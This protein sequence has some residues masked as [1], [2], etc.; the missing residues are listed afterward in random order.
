MEFALEVELM[1]K[2]AASRV[3]V[4]PLRGVCFEP[5]RVCIITERMSKG[6]VLNVIRSPQT[7]EDLLKEEPWKSSISLFTDDIV[8][9][10]IPFAFKLYIAAQCA[11][12]LRDLHDAG[13]V[14]RDVKAKNFLVDEKW[15]VYIADLGFGKDSTTSDDDTLTTISKVYRKFQHVAQISFLLCLWR[16]ARQPLGTYRYMAP[17]YVKDAGIKITDKLDIYSFGVMLWEIFTG[18]VPFAKFRSETALKDFLDEVMCK[19]FSLSDARAVERERLQP[20]GQSGISC[21]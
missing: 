12:R 17:E 8:P 6:D 14:H 1:S 21:V 20:D 13:I 5:S 2:A 15:T 16:A 7:V 9:L 19:W 10:K 18:D 4:L 11:A 3:L